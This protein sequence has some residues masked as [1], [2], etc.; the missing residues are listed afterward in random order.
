MA[1]WHDLPT[2]IKSQIIREVITSL[3]HESTSGSMQVLE[4]C[5]EDYPVRRFRSFCSL[6]RT[7]DE[8]RR[9]CLQVRILD[10]NSRQF[11]QSVQ[12]Q[13]LFSMGLTTMLDGGYN[14]K[15]KFEPSVVQEIFGTFWRNPRILSDHEF[16]VNISDFLR[17]QIGMFVAME[18]FFSNLPVTDPEG[19]TKIFH[20]PFGPAN[21]GAQSYY[22][23]QPGSRIIRSWELFISDVA[24]GWIALQDVENPSS[25]EWLTIDASNRR[26]VPFDLF[27]DILPEIENC[28][29][30]YFKESELSLWYLI[31]FKKRKVYDHEYQEIKSFEHYEKE[32]R[33]AR[34]L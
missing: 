4:Y 34:Y 25:T 1:Q 15:L 29:F 30:V 24:A 27:D 21:N 31:D 22:L 14:L 7:S 26:G 20:F 18:E 28:W 10:L 23:I 12:C 8:F 19:E 9:L 32:L 2:E 3:Y 13:F 6:L 16:A 5:Y 17:P 11:F 33:D